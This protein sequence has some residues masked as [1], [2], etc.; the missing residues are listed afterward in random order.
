MVGRAWG[1]EELDR[2]LAC[3]SRYR[4]D[5]RSTGVAP[6]LLEDRRYL[7]YT[8]AHSYDQRQLT[9]AVERRA[10]H[11]RSAARTLLAQPSDHFTC[12]ASRAGDN[13]WISEILRGPD[14][15][16]RAS[17]SA[18]CR[19]VVRGCSCIDHHPFAPCFTPRAQL[20][21]SPP[22]DAQIATKPAQIG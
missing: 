17:G 6:R 13:A 9:R 16:A 7:V 2:L 3:W 1:Q 4:P 15:R 10:G 22:Q 5:C 11:I 12:T 18:Q 20:P 21:N 8:L 19:R 14:F